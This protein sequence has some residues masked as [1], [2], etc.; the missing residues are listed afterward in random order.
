MTK[1]QKKRKIT[2]KIEMTY[3]VLSPE[4]ERVR[5]RSLNNAF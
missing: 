4:V 1:K 2:A 5:E 3:F